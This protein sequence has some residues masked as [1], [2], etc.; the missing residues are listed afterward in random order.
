MSTNV[1]PVIADIQ[2]AA[3]ISR[4]SFDRDAASIPIEK[5]KSR[6]YIPSLKMILKIFPI[7]HPFEL[8][9]RLIYEL[10]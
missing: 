9:V 10:R 6:K 1:P 4:G 3:E 2:R 7:E 5:K 8:L